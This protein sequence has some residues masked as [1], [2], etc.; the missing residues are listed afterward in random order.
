MA[1]CD[2]EH[3][4]ERLH[5]AGRDIITSFQAGDKLYMRVPD[6]TDHSNP[7]TNVYDKKPLFDISHN[8]GT[9][10]GIEISKPEDV[11]LCIVGEM[12]NY[13]GK[14]PTT[15]V[16]SNVN[17][18]GIYSEERTEPDVGHVRLELKHDPLPCMYPHCVIRIIVDEVELLSKN[19]YKQHLQKKKKLK[20]WVRQQL[21]V[22][23]MTAKA[24]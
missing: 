5:A 11:L 13:E 24:S 22:M 18:D 4:P 17:D 7:A 6:H 1:D 15:I 20:H 19:D 14:I 8:I 3:I 21:G 12:K 23:I 9:S 16:L 2:L 10:T